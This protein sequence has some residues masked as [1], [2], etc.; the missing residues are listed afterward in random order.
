MS[1]AARAFMAPLLAEHRRYKELPALVAASPGA[2][3]PQPATSLQNTFVCQ[4]QQRNTHGRIFGGFL[5]RRAYELAFATTYTHAGT[6]PAFAKVRRAAW[7]GR[8]QLAR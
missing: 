4:P 8:L 5:M 3:V 2:V 7:A 1:A 6:R